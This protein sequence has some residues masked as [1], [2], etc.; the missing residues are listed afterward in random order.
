MNFVTEEQKALEIIQEIGFT[1]ILKLKQFNSLPIGRQKSLTIKANMMYMA[2][3]YAIGDGHW[4]ESDAR[5]M[6][7]VDQKEHETRMRHLY[8][9]RNV[10]KRVL[11]NVMNDLSLQKI[12]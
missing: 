11:I 8:G 6:V 5:G 12:K 3:C 2:T 10:L 9:K 1:D 4:R 7:G